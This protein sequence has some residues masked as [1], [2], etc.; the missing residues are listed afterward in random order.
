MLAAVLARSGKRVSG[1]GAERWCE[2]RVL[3]GPASGGKGSKGRN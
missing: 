2:D 3:H 1:T